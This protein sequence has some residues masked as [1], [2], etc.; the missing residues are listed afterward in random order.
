MKVI[1]PSKPVWYHAHAQVR[2][3]TLNAPVA[4]AQDIVLQPF[5]CTILRAK[6]LANALELF[7]F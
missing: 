7:L 2:N 4:I 5:V 6:L 3:E 1:F